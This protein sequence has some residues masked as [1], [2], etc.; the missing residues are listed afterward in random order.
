MVETL[1]TMDTPTAMERRKSNNVL[2]SYCSV[3]LA[4]NVL[5]VCGTFTLTGGCIGRD[6]NGQQ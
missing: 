3:W 1:R 2:H 6:C 5:Y 4:Y